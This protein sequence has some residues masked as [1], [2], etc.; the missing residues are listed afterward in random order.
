[1][2]RL[3]DAFESYQDRIAEFREQLKYPEGAA[4]AAVGRFRPGRCTLMVVGG[5]A[6]VSAAP[7]PRPSLLTSR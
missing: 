7:A 4:G 2:P 5:G 6:V 1:M 3:S